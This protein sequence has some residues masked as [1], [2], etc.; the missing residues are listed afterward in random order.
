MDS[1]WILILQMKQGREDAFDIFVRR[2]YGDILKYCFFHCRDK[3][4]S[5]D[6][7]QEVFVRFF[8][9]L[10]RYQHRGKAKNYLYTIA[11]NLCRSAGRAMAADPLE[12]LPEIVQTQTMP[13]EERLTLEDAVRRLPQELR[14]VVV[15]HY[16]QGLK[17]SETASVL[18]IGLPL[19]KYRLKRAKEILRKE[20]T[21]GLE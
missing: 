15:L 19:T 6:M 4:L 9:A 20:L 3:G 7:T 21:D 10:S 14:E 12:L 8:S 16:Y 5:E 1:D 2:Y 13:L 18:K 11:G 17:L